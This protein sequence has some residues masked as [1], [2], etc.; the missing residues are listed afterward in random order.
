MPMDS[1]RQTGTNPNPSPE[2]Q[3]PAAALPPEATGD[4][5][6]SDADVPFRAAGRSSETDDDDAESCSGGFSGGLFIGIATDD[7]TDK[8]ED[9]DDMTVEVDMTEV[10]SMMAVPW[11]RRTGEYAANGDGGCAPAEGGG[12]LAGGGRAAAES[13]RLFWE[14][15]IAHGY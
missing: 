15:C 10:D 3:P 4:S 7:A 14:A 13:N 8:F 5:D 9:D 1:T 12:K 2:L 6:D 11:W